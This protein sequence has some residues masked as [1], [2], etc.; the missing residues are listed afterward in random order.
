MLIL[1]KTAFILRSGGPLIQIK[2]NA[3][4]DN[5]WRRILAKTSYGCASGGTP[6]LNKHEATRASGAQLILSTNDFGINKGAANIQVC[7]LR[8]FNESWSSTELMGSAVFVDYLLK[9]TTGIS[10]T[11]S[12]LLKVACIRTTMCNWLMLLA[13]LKKAPHCLLASPSCGRLSRH[14]N[15]YAT[16]DSNSTH[17]WSNWCYA[18][19]RF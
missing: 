13:I 15:A 16:A 11:S 3:D 1:R 14:A 17:R 19:E 12:L 18:P 2:S 8:L 10:T 5:G 9:P 7:L 6:I 4:D